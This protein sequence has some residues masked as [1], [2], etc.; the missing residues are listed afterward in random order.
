MFT[1][2]K[3]LLS[4]FARLSSRL[5]E[6]LKTLFQRPTLDAATLEEIE[7]LLYEADLGIELSASL[8]AQ[9]EDFFRRQKGKASPDELL[10]FLKEKLL[11]LFPPS[12]PSPLWENKPHVILVVGVNGSGKTTTLAKIAA[13]YRKEGKKVLLAAGDTFRA[14]AVEQLETWG[15]KLGIDV[16]RA[17]SHADPAAVAFDALSAGIAR[18]V[19]VLLIDTAGRLQT[20]TALMQELAKVRKTCEKKLPGA[21]HETLLVLDATLGQNSLDQAKIFHS[22][23]PITGIALTKLDGSAKGGIAACIQHSLKIPILWAGLGEKEED[24]VPFD[25]ES[26]VSAL[27]SL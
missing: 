15:K 12:S 23:T 9:V 14:A 26:Y 20:K 5:G 7:R 8:T 21:P 27:L 16:V 3:K 1:F 13:R 17:A 4:P 19:D 22:F 11:A 10:L 25:P 18:G 2:F 6:K 24:L